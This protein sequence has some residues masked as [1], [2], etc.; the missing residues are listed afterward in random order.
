VD[1]PAAD[2]R[3]MVVAFPAGIVRTFV[4]N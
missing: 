3:G 2:H 1:S 4:T